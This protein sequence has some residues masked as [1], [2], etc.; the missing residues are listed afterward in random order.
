MPLFRSPDPSDLDAEL[1]DRLLA[2]RVDPDDAPQA[3]KGVARVLAAATT[4]PTASEHAGEERAV[5]QFSQEAS[6]R[7]PVR[8]ARA[9]RIA[10]PL[11]AAVA[12]VAILAGAGAAAAA[13]ALPAPAQ[14]LAHTVLGDIGVD[15][16]APSSD[17]HPT[18]TTT[19]STTTSTAAAG[20]DDDGDRLHARAG[21]VPGHP[22]HRRLHGGQRRDVSRQ[23]RHGRVRARQPGEVPARELSASHSSDPPDASDPAGA[24]DPADSPDASDAAHEHHRRT[25]P[26]HDDPRQERQRSRQGEAMSLL[27]NDIARTEA[28]VNRGSTVS[29]EQIADAAYSVISVGGD[30]EAV[31]RAVLGLGH[32]ARTDLALAA[33][34]CRR[35]ARA[36][37]EDHA[38]RTAAVNLE[39]AA[40]SGL[41]GSP[42][43]CTPPCTA[44]F[45]SVF[46]P[47]LR[48]RARGGHRPALTISSRQTSETEPRAQPVAR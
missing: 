27:D 39:A 38:W 47:E 10:R 22:W 20:R 32:L 14:R 5:R 17:G 33:I 21:S 46:A 16:P 1:L 30:L 25:E 19:R 28:S 42:D 34:S 6:G 13:G 12:S 23:P 4:A 37:E 45:R 7:E 43:R 18:S 26:V 41:F 11:V 9:N 8:T 15:V 31:L 44:G 48:R 40:R 2:G 29:G 36:D 24:S 35:R 3:Y